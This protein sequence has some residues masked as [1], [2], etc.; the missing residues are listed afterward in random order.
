MKLLIADFN[1][2]DSTEFLT[3]CLMNFDGDCSRNTCDCDYNCSRDDDCTS[4][5][6]R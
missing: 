1:Q 3:N 5:T 4:D 6:D 2:V